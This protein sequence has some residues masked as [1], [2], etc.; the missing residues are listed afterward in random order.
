[1]TQQ[2]MLRTALT[3]QQDPSQA[4]TVNSMFAVPQQQLQR[5][6]GDVVPFPG[7]GGSGSGTMWDLQSALQQARSPGS[8]ISIVPQPTAQGVLNIIQQHGLLNP[9]KWAK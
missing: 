3:A 2:E 6:A 7:S 5:M 4:S 9:N 8:N 1:M